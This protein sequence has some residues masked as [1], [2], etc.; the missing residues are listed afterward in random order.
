MPADELGSVF[1]S[2]PVQV[3]QELKRVGK[4]LDRE[5]K[6]KDKNTKFMLRKHDT[7]ELSS[8]EENEEIKSITVNEHDPIDDELIPGANIDVT[9]R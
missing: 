6:R 8:E 9:V 4:E 5:K 2:D 1:R 3:H 7:V